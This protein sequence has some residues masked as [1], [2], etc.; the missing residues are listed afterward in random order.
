MA[1]CLQD[2]LIDILQKYF[3]F[4]C[5]CAKVSPKWNVTIFQRHSGLDS[6]TFIKEVIKRQIKVS[7]AFPED[8]IQEQRFFKMLFNCW[9]TNNPY[10]IYTI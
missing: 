9:M 2:F 3:V 4:Q 1:Y 5:T 6:T 7:P 8:N 10:Y